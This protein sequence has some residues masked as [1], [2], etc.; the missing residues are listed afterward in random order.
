MHRSV[1]SCLGVYIWSQ[2]T[3]AA[4]NSAESHASSVDTIISPAVTPSKRAHAT[5]NAPPAPSSPVAAVNSLSVPFSPGMIERDVQTEKLM[6]E[7]GQLRA[8]LAA[9]TGSVASA[10]RTASV[11]GEAL[12]AD[13]SGE[14]VD[15]DGQQAGHASLE[16]GVVTWLQ[17]KRSPSLQ[18]PNNKCNG[19]LLILFCNGVCMHKLNVCSCVN[20][21]VLGHE[22]RSAAPANIGDAEAD[23]LVMAEQSKQKY[24]DIVGRLQKEA[25]KTDSGCVDQ[26]VEDQ[27]DSMDSVT[28]SEDQSDQAEMED[29]DDI[30]TLSYN[31]SLLPTKGCLT[32][33]R[34]DWPT[35]PLS[36]PQ[37]CFL[38]VSPTAGEPRPVH[39]ARRLRNQEY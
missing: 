31:P 9:V 4:R 15:E 34:K 27:Q 12:L 37:V 32:Q 2:V 18:V 5:R 23:L 13:P 19:W 21:T 10:S 3:W 22:Q 38:L 11:S 28:S 8:A 17:R 36:P 1:H 26:S 16:A 14:W 24:L 39:T 33:Y 29:E 7:M 25:L 35:R 30:L 20:L 6:E